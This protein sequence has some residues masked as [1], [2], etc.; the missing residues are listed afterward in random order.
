MADR[1]RWNHFIYR[2]WAP[3][4]DWLINLSFFVRARKEALELLDLQAGERVL[5]V[6]VGTGA[7][8]PF[9]PEGVDAIGIDLSDSMLKKA[10]AKLPIEGREIELKQANAEDLPFGENE[11]DAV[12]LTLILSVAG[13]G[14]QALHEAVRVMRPGGRALIFDKFLPPNC[15]PPLGRRVLNTL[16]TKPFGTDINRSLEPM[17]EGSPCR[18]VSSQPSLFSGAYQ[19]VLL[20]KEMSQ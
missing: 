8:L 19:I 12:I 3:F 14:K 7:D 15:K 9:L 4:Y 1:N 6:G 16:V 2:L 5:L 10:R 17:L 18:V 13:D 20:E 11:F